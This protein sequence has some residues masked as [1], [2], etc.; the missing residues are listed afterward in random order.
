MRHVKWRCGA[1]RSAAAIKANRPA[2]LST[3]VRIAKASRFWLQ[4]R[5]YQ[6][7]PLDKN[8]KLD[9]KPSSPATVCPE[10]SKP[11]DQT[12]KTMEKAPVVL[13]TNSLR[14][15]DTFRLYILARLVLAAFLERR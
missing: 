5:K 3:N 10:Y 2:K 13:R 8:I 7:I 6:C 14:A 15:E 9:R 11:P 12:R 4:T 1:E